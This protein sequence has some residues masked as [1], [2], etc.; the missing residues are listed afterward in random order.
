MVFVFL[1]SYT[2]VRYD[3]LAANIRQ[4]RR[5]VQETVEV[6]I[7]RERC[8]QLLAN[9]EFVEVLTT[10]RSSAQYTRL[11]PLLFLGIV[12]V[13][14]IA[15]LLLVQINAL[16]YQNDLITNV[17]RVWLFLDLAALIWFFSRT[18]IHVGVTGRFVQNRTL[19]RKTNE[20]TAF[21]KRSI[22]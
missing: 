19:G 13:F 15:V 3:M 2:L 9:V 4:F 21:H 8:R 6:E 20:I 5:E 10:P 11:W 14:P 17:Q 16:R 1:H 22:A 7:D 18:P 12:V